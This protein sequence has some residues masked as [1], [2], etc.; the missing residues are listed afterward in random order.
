MKPGVAPSTM[1][2]LNTSAVLRALAGH[3]QPVT[4]AALVDEVA[5]SRRTLDLILGRLCADGWVSEIAP[6]ASRAEGGRPPR[7]FAF[8][9]DRALVAAARIDTHAVGAV[10][11]D[12]RG[13]I[14]G[15]AVRALRDY[16]DTASSID[17]VAAAV[18]EA[19]GDSGLPVDRL[20]AGAVASGGAVGEDGIVHRLIHA[21]AWNGFDLV[22]ALGGRLGIP[23][24]A[25]NDANLAAL[26]EHW[27]GVASE[28]STFAWCI[29]GNRAGVGIVIRGAVHRGFQ[30]AAGEIVEAGALDTERLERAPLGLL[31]SPVAAERAQGIAVADAARHGDKAALAQLDVFAGQIAELLSTLAW[32]IAPE[33]VVLGGGLE[34]AADLLLPRVTEAMR[35]LRTPAI[36][37]RATA[38]GSDAPLVGGVKLVLDRMDSAL[39]GPT[40]SG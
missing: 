22:G 6:D 40:V 32:T 13:R 18:T 23:V 7:S 31:T 12:V 30:G 17:D 11:A 5:L 8:E 20:R 36:E 33:V 15:R 29:L 19:V 21:P 34:A 37:L 3:D 2:R 38:L 24:F 4:M 27:C 9:A 10:V 25:D 39:F 35:V 16:H 28:T 1:R 14:R 26:A